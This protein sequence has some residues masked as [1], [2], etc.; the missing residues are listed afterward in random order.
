MVNFRQETI[1]HLGNYRK[2][3]LNI[4]KPGLFAYGSKK[5]K[6]DHIL[7]LNNSKLN[8]LGKY[9]QEFWAS[10]HSKISFHRYFHHLNSSQALC[11]NLFFP[12]IHEQVMNFLLSQMGIKGVTTISFSAFEFSSDLEKTHPGQRS[13]NFDFFLQ[14]GDKGKLYFEIKYTEDG[15]GRAP[16]DDSHIAK[17][18]HTYKS[19][20]TGNP[21]I[22]LKYQKMSR[23]LEC[24]Q[25]SRNLVHI[26]NSAD[27]VFIIPRNNKVIFRQ[28]TNARDHIL[29]ASGRKHFHLVFLEDLI[30]NLVANVKNQ[31]L[32][33][34]LGQ[35]KEKYLPKTVYQ[36]AATA[37][38]TPNSDF[39]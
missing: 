14:L 9:R 12:F 19:L 22:K 6:K 37:R 33:D 36:V 21:Y 17:F 2:Y 10:T 16:L 29:T 11:I 30:P 26:S 27:V 8:I 5:Y 39:L 38:A 23:F 18:E 28:A 35:F 20:L 1:E 4:S 32:R 25:I 13:T 24:Y 15:F 31:K 34:H 7:P 3:V